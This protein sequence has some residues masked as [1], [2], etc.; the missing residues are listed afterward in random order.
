MRFLVHSKDG[1]T[2]GG[3]CRSFLQKGALLIEKAV[4]LFLCYLSLSDINSL[5]FCRVLF[6][7]RERGDFVTALWCVSCHFTKAGTK[8]NI[9][10]STIF[11]NF[12]TLT[13]FYQ[14]I[15]LNLLPNAQFTVFQNDHAIRTAYTHLNWNRSK[16]TF[17]LPL[18][19]FID[20]HSLMFNL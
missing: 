9:F 1:G 20:N 5:I 7:G 8:K 10:D 11:N 6:Q 16:C 15:I 18:Y 4:G 17:S 3:D 12:S 2:C 14:Q 13:E 19:N